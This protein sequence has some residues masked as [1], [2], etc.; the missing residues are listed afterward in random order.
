MVFRGIGSVLGSSGPSAGGAWLSLA[1]DGL[2]RLFLLLEIFSCRDEDARK[3]T[4]R[5]GQEG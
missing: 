3:K 4:M 2:C 5:A 1:K